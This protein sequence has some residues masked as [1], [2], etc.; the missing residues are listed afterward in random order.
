MEAGAE[1]GVEAEVDVDEAEVEV[2]V[3]EVEAK[4]DV[5]EVEAEADVAEVASMAFGAELARRSI[6]TRTELSKSMLLKLIGS[7]VSERSPTTMK[8]RPA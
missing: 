8:R 3:D 7:S 6:G 2:D 5:D 1:A 4:V